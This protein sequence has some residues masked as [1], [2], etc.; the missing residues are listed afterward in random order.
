MKKRISI[1]TMDTAILF[2]LLTKGIFPLSITITKDGMD[3][4]KELNYFEDEDGLIIGTTKIPDPSVLVHLYVIATKPIPKYPHGV[5]KTIAVTDKIF[6]ED[7]IVPNEEMK[8]GLQYKFDM[9]G[10]LYKALSKFN[11]PPLDG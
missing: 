2:K 5:Q 3:F 8:K 9:D 1:Y 6:S 7:I 11:R 4:G 10:N